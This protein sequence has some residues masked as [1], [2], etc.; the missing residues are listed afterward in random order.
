MFVE[1]RQ[2]KIMQ[3]LREYNEVDV[4]SLTKVLSVSEATIRRDLEKME[5]VGVL[6]RTH[7]GAIL[8]NEDIQRLKYQEDSDNL[9]TREINDIGRAASKFLVNDEVVAIGAGE[10]GLSLARNINKNLKCTIVTNDV[11][12]MA[13]LL[14]YR[15]IDV[16]MIGGHVLKK[17]ENYIFSSGE[18]AMRM[19]SEF[20]VN[21]AFLSV[22]GISFQDGLT[23]KDY[24][25]ALIWKELKNI[26]DKTIVM[27][28][29]DAFEH[30]HFVKLIS[31]DEI[32]QVISS[33]KLNDNYKKYFF[34]NGISIHI[35]HEI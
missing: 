2:E 30:R 20:H 16:I 26:S 14:N 24:E 15:D 25:Y 32:D 17:R 3:L 21:K 19:L 6:H 10:L 23:V 9:R 33:V 7:G 4:N 35:S 28:T 5:K 29:A 27:A 1:Q 11:M 18:S 8:V 22:D 34:E 31:I 13:E 12:I